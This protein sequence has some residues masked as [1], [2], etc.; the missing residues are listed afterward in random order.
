MNVEQTRNENKLLLNVSGRLDTTTAPQLET[1]IDAELEG[2]TDLVIDCEKLE[3]ISSAGLRLLLKTQKKM[4]GVGSMKLVH[5]NE[6]NMEV[7]SITGF[8]QILT[9]E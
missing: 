5:V 8:D 6:A 1:I 9:I 2:V 7:F 4:N 3:Y